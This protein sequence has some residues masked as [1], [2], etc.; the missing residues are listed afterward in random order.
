MSIWLKGDIHGEHTIHLL[1]SKDF[2]EGKKLT[3][4]DYVI[5]LGDFGLIWAQPGSKNIKEEIH[6]LKW[7]SS[8]PWTTLFV[9]GN[10]ENFNRLYSDEFKDISMF[11][12]TVKQIHD[13]VFWLKRGEIYVIDGHKIFTFGGAQSVD[14][15]SRASNISWWDKELATKAEED[16]ALDNLIKHNMD[17]DYIL[18][19]T[20]PDY[21]V[22]LLLSNKYIFDNRHDP[23]TK[24]LDHIS[25][26][27]KFKHWYFGHFHVDRN[28]DELYTSLYDK[29]ILIEDHGKS[30]LGVICED[31]RI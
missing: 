28:I 29:I 8:K 19:H 21:I 31:N 12:G 9:D 7:L 23:T 5:I 3:K 20:A 13:T 11:K 25:C 15:N 4:E 16:Y 14:K 24:F 1:A 26:N 17:V 30:M 6:W 22:D 27:V 10:H 18:T 2:P